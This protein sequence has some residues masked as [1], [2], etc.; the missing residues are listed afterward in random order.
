M[1][2][3]ELSMIAVERLL[4]NGRKVFIVE[5]VNEIPVI[6]EGRVFVEIHRMHN[7]E[8]GSGIPLIVRRTHFCLNRLS[9]LID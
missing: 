4:F 2:C 5:P 6:C 9:V 8:L 3:D 7:S 1:V